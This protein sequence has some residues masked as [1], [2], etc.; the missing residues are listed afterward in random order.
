MTPSL[1]HAALFW[2]SGAVIGAGALWLLIWAMFRD[3]SRGRQR[4]PR[5]W[6]NMSGTPGTRCPECG[7][8][9]RRERRLFR[10]RRYWK[11]GAVAVLLLMC[12]LVLA[13]MPFALSNMWWRFAPTPV[14]IFKSL[15]PSISAQNVEYELLERLKGGRV[16]RWEKRWVAA[17][18]GRCLDAYRHQPPRSEPFSVLGLI[19]PDGGAV[20]PSVVALLNNDDEANRI[21]SWSVLASIGL[22]DEREIARLNQMLTDPQ[23]PYILRQRV[24]NRLGDSGAAAVGCVPALTQ[25]IEN[26]ALHAENNGFIVGG[27]A[28]TLGRIGPDAAI[29]LPVLRVLAEDET[30]PLDRRYAALFARS[31]ITRDCPSEK[32]FQVRMLVH[33]DVRW[34]RQAA[35]WLQSY[36]ISEDGLDCVR[37]LLEA[38]GDPDPEVSASA[39]TALAAMLTANPKTTTLLTAITHEGDDDLAVLATAALKRGGQSL[40][41]VFAAPP[42]PPAPPAAPTPAPDDKP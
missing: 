33:D 19:G 15:D 31:L 36:D 20:I 24:T 6:Y 7:H 38:C 37:P 29:A 40:S 41:V 11:R 5:C 2:T 26:P 8:E 30:Q 35:R 28:V 13:A 12:S 18:A 4:C 17:K 39:Q 21:W 10:T 16:W 14:L 25:I 23:M 27:A 32:Q 1:P 42:S 22:R 34:R 3:R 9:A